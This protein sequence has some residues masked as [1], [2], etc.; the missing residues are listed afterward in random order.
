LAAIKIQDKND[1]RWCR[2]CDDHPQKRTCTCVRSC[3]FIASRLSGTE[4]S[5]TV[6]A[7]IVFLKKT[8]EVGRAD[9]ERFIGMESG[10]RCYGCS[11]F[12]IWAG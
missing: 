10:K 2:M 7:S 11:T 9:K 6:A 5:H 12:C 1:S 8:D 4:T 3:L